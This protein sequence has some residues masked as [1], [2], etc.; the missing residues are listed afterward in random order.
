MIDATKHLLQTCLPPGAT[1]DV[2]RFIA[3]QVR[4]H[5]GT[6]FLVGGCVR[7]ALLGITAKD[8][9]IE[10][11]GMTPD[12]LLT[13]LNVHFSLNT[14]G[15]SFS[16]IKLSDFPVDIALP[17][18]ENKTAPGHRG[19]LVDTIPD[20]PYDEACARRDFTMNAILLNPLTGNIIDPWNGQQDINR[21]LLRHVSEHFSE[22]PLRVLRGM[23]FA[24]RFSLTIAPETITICRTMSSENLSRER[25]SAEWEK[26]FVKG[27][28]PSLGLTFLHDCGWIRDYPELAALIN[29]PQHPDWHP[30]GDVWTHTLH[31]MDALPYVRTNN[32]ADNLIV[33]IAVLC[34]DFGK[35]KTTVHQA[36]GRIT[37]YQHEVAGTNRVRQ[38]IARLWN[39]PHFSDQ[40]VRLVNAHMRPLM[41]VMQNASDKAYR[42]LAVDV[43][44]M[45]LLADVVECDSRATPPNPPALD[46]LAKFRKRAEALAVTKEPPK[47]ILMG[48]H[49]IDRGLKPG[50]KFGE[51][52]SQCY[53]AQIEGTFTNETSALTYLDRL[54]ENRRTRKAVRA[55][56]VS[57]PDE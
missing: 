32:D 27:I 22:D 16:V 53:N 37:A 11:Y 2:I 14:V 5:D 26:L 10:I 41:L 31:A 40:V 28:Q 1:T 38:F 56:L 8:Y 47:P 33:A 43:G 46:S 45:D 55:D 6:A 35:P 25:I 54:L 13:F 50:K 15:A 4:E 48:R 20:L 29:C 49:L 7:D 52:L 44:R 24:A 42:R 23:Q 9:D 34:H 57:A 17:R 18:R 51:I 30:E 12:R 21:R 39:Q 3:T 19:F 36:D